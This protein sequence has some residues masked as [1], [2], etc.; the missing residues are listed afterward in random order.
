MT[1]RQATSQIK[2][3]TSVFQWHETADDDTAKAAEMSFLKQLFVAREI[4]MKLF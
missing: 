2:Y 3:K 4:K 1:E